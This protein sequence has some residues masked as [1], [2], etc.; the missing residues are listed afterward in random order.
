MPDGRAA[1][2]AKTYQVAAAAAVRGQ[3]FGPGRSAVHKRRNH[4][5]RRIKSPGS[6]DPPGPVWMAVA[7]TS[8]DLVIIYTRLNALHSFAGWTVARKWKLA[9]L[10]REC[11]S[12]SATADLARPQK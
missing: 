3:H 5:R 4:G 8:R 11:L 10:L 7:M 9:W 12:G 6:V 2:L 1:R